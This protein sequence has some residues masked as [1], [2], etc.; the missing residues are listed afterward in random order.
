MAD[1]IKTT[2]H[3]VTIVVC[4]ATC[5]E[6]NLYLVLQIMQ[7]T[8]KVIV[9]INLIDEAQKKQ[10]FINFSKLSK[11]LQVPVIPMS[12]RKNYGFNELK[13]EINN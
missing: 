6:R 1:F 11:I 3:D 7:L 12:A 5:L 8:P 9:C 2:F 13:E 4:D 10:I